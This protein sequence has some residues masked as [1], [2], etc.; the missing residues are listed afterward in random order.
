MEKQQ[1]SLSFHQA[2]KIRETYDKGATQN[3][4]ARYYDVSK[5]T[6]KSIVQGKSYVRPFTDYTK[7]NK[8]N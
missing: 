2:Q 8:N 6:I 4:L 5:G 3:Q 1:R 7:F